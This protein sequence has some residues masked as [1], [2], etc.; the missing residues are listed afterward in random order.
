M[1]PPSDSDLRSLFPDQG[2]VRGVFTTKAA[3]YRT[4]RP[5][6]P[7]ALY[8]AL[9]EAGAFPAM[10][11]VVADLGA[12]TGLFSAGLL[13]RGHHV[14]AVEPNAAMRAEA[15][16]SLGHFPGF[17]SVDGGA[18]ATTLESGSVD[19]VTAAQAFHWFEVEPTRSECLRILRPGGQ[20]ALI[21][22]DR[23]LADP[24]QQQLESVLA[25]AGGGVRE[26]ANVT[27]FFGSASAVTLALHHEHLLDRAGLHSLA[28]SRSYMPVRDSAAG[29]Q[30]LQR[31]DAIFD[32][33]ASEDRVTMRYR[34]TATLGRPSAV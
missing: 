9:R 27:R 18:E 3:D 32:Q 21:W 4:A 12:G 13:A 31:L 34:T 17:R 6:Y 29:I 33:Y 19:L 8:D 7:D 22:N 26:K 24:L 2:G 16:A 1:M 25:Q 5:A 11:S 30:A 10:P 20:V 14:L 28:F 23:D 15:E